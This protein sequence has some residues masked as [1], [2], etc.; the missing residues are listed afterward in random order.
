MLLL[1]LLLLLLLPPPP[2]LLLLLLLLLPPP[3]LL[4]LL[5]LPRTKP[6]Q[7]RRQYCM[8]C[9]LAAAVRRVDAA[10]QRKPLIEVTCYTTQRNHFRISARIYGVGI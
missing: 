1:L 8:Q 3:L 5:L 9:A 7:S 2:L 10:K 4:L 6:A